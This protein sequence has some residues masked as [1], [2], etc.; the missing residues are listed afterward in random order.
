[1]IFMFVYF[2]LGIAG[3]DPLVDRPNVT[4]WVAR[5]Q[6]KFSPFYEEAHKIV[7]QTAEEYK[8]YVGEL[9]KKK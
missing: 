8:H 1:M 5:V 2:Y 7:E 6:S 4:K 9:S 3:F